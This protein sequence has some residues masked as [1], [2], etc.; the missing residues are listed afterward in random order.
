MWIK[1]KMR[2]KSLMYFV[3]RGHYLSYIL[4]LSHVGGDSSAVPGAIG[5]LRAGA[6]CITVGI[7]IRVHPVVFIPPPCWLLLQVW[8]GIR[9][10][11]K[12]C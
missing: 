2:L 4:R 6:G 5:P 7:I 10:D 11:M 8:E 12:L 1:V 9:S 3:L